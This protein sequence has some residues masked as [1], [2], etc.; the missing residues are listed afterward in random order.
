VRVFLVLVLAA[1]SMAEAAGAKDVCLSDGTGSFYV[2][3][4]VKKLKPRGSTPLQGVFVFRDPF[5]TLNPMFGA[6]VM[7]PEGAI[8]ASVFI[9]TF[10]SGNFS[11][12]MTLDA[13]W[14]G[15]ANEDSDGDFGNDPGIE[16]VLTRIDCRTVVFPATQN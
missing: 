14:N 6:A 12:S 13:E 11:H 8:K 3:R 15:T 10:A 16:I 4:G 9:H 2:F 1:I 7:T 5:N